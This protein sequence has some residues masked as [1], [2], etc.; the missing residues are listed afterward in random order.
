M[1]HTP[2]RP[3][4][5]VGCP[6][7][8][9]TMLRLMLDAH[10]RIAIP[11][12]SH[13]VGGL[14]LR[15]LRLGKRPLRALELALA[16]TELHEWDADPALLR[17]SVEAARPRTLADML[18]ALF[19]AY[20][21]A[22]GKARW[23]DKTPGYVRRLPA[24]ARLFPDAL[25]VHLIRDGRRVAASLGEVPWGPASA[26]SA[27]RWW[28]QRV[29][30][31]RRAG[32]HLGPERY[33]EVRYEDLVDDPQAA[34]RRVCA[35]LGEEFDDA[36]T[37]PDLRA[38][39]RLEERS[40]NESV[41]RPPTAGVRADWAARMTPAERDAAEWTCFRLLRELGYDAERPRLRGLVLAAAFRAREVR[42]LPWLW[43]LRAWLRPATRFW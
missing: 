7:S 26:A 38:P 32:R 25:F 22:Q 28:R 6:R 17:A 35:F 10:P 8:G 11:P 2:E 5:V 4:F 39:G 9:T 42:H 23:G 20:A 27:A 34:L 36:M 18:R 24:L 40:W 21:E 12:E 14:T 37:R 30:K 31:G 33:L 19:G 15:R 43:H 1:S 16:H 13:F 3:F 29:R 41:R